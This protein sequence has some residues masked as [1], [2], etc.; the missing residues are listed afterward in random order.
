VRVCQRDGVPGTDLDRAG[1]DTGD[2]RFAALKLLD[3]DVEPGLLE[4]AQFLRI[5][6]IGLRFEGADG[7]LNERLVLRVRRSAAEREDE[8]EG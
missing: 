6:R 7:D 8:R 4:K 3:V 5:V 1:R 2:D